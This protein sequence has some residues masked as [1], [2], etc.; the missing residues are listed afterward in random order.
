MV[1]V[2]FPRQGF[3]APIQHHQELCSGQ[4]QTGPL[5]AVY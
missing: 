2:V 4:S 3:A 1:V 5:S